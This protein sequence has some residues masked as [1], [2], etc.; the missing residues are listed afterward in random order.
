M[1]DDSLEEKED[2]EKGKVER[3]EGKEEGKQ[4]EREEIDEEGWGKEEG[5]EEEE[6]DIE[7]DELDYWEDDELEE[8][9]ILLICVDLDEGSFM[10][11]GYWQEEDNSTL[12][13]ISEAGSKVLGGC[14]QNYFALRDIDAG[15]ELL[16]N[17]GE[18]ALPHGWDSF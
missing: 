4:G 16:V 15:E 6:E 8:G 3:Q 14:K 11:S 5:D 17:Y 2:E 13:C 12:G 7:W 18:F 1:G 10:N 9:Q